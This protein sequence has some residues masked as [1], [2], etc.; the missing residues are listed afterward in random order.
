MQLDR[1]SFMDDGLGVGEALMDEDG[2]GNRPVSKG[3]ALQAFNF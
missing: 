1:S 2:D 3:G